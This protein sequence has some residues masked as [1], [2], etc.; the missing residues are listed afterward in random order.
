MF[1]VLSRALGFFWRRKED[2]DPEGV[3]AQECATL[4][5]VHGVVTRFCSD[6][7]M[8]NDQIYFAS[9]DVVGKGPLHIGQKVIAV[10]EENPASGVLKA[11]RVE[12]VSYKWEDDDSSPRDTPMLDQASQVLIGNITSCR[13]D[14]GCI[15]QTTVFSM[16]D[17]CDSYEPYKGDWVQARYYINPVTW[18]SEA[19]DVKP[20]RYKSIDQVSITILYG[21]SGVIDDSIFFTLDSLRLPVG[22]YPCRGD[23][24]SAVVI[25]SS[26]SCYI[27]RALCMTPLDRNRFSS[28]DGETS[29]ERGLALLLQNKGGLEVSSMTNFGMVK[30]GEIKTLSIC[31]ENRGKS[32]HL[33]ICCKLAGWEKESPFKFE[34]FHQD[35]RRPPSAS[36]PAALTVN[37]SSSRPGT[38]GFPG[39]YTGHQVF[40]GILMAYSRCFPS[41]VLCADYSSLSAPA[42]AGQNAA[43]VIG[44]GPCDPAQL[45]ASMS[46]VALSSKPCLS[47]TGRGILVDRHSEGSKNCIGGESGNMHEESG[48]RADT[49]IV[50]IQSAAAEADETIPILPGREVTI[51]ITC[52]AKNPG[53]FNDLLLLCFSNFIIGRNLKVMVRS[54]EE[55]LIAATEPYRKRQSMLPDLCSPQDKIVVM[56]SQNRNFRRQLPCFVPAYSVPE[57]LRKCVQQKMDVLTFEP[58]LAELLNISNYQKK[59]ATLLWLEDIFAE[60]EAKEFS[61]SGV[62]L[63]KNGG[64]LLLEVPGLAECRPSVCQGDKVLLRRQSHLDLVIEYVTYVNEIHDEELTLRVNPELVQS[65]HSEPMDVEFTVCRTTS[66]RCQFAVEQGI[67]LG[68]RVLFPESLILQFPQFTVPWDDTEDSV[69][70]QHQGVEKLA[71]ESTRV[72]NVQSSFIATQGKNAVTEVN[73]LTVATQVSRLGSQWRSSKMKGRKFFNPLLNEHQKLAVKRILGGECR[74]TPYILFGPPGTGKTVTL[75]EAVLQIHY[76]LSDSRI[77][78]CAPSNSATDLVCLRLHE[79]QMLEPGAMVRVNASSRIEE[80]IHDAVKPYCK[81]GEDIWKASRFRIVIC[82]CSSAGMFYQIGLRI[83]HFTHIFVDEAGQASEPECLIPLGLMSEENGQVVLAG[84]PWQLGPVIKCRLAKAYGLNVSLLERLM[85]RPMYQR[86]QKTYGACGS[87]NPLLV[88]KL[89]KNYR[90]HPALLELPSKLFY[91][92]EL[93]ACAKGAVVNAFL[94]W[95]KLP[96]KGFPLIFHGVRGSEMREGSN[97]S[98]FNPTEAVHIIRYCCILAKNVTTLVS[99]KDI[100]VITPYRKQ[101]EKIRILLRI[102]ALSDIKVGSVE[103]FQGQEYLVILISTVRSCEERLGE[104]EKYLLGFLSNPRRFNVAVTRP[105]ALLIVVG[106]PHVLIKDPCFS[107]FLEYSL[108]NDS[109][110]GCD[111]PLGLESLQHCD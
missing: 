85:T 65:Y 2:D 79:S 22:Y 46:Q 105:K 75:I 95:E 98:W 110:V 69:N 55:M 101:V 108:F 68:P 37:L 56:A 88:T 43:A 62:T 34:M 73:T 89:V 100:G 81:D 72:Q 49:H 41:T 50:A 87:Y 78:I 66:R 26:Q 38:L 33:L 5:N 14:G 111:L 102:M 92:R 82:T 71:E 91:H 93:E 36:E 59:F 107:A 60:Q 42:L 51:V 48:M 64:F 24:V 97:P 7:G 18:C 96:R 19:Y 83:G 23:V 67:H 63:R 30:Q 4:K 54:E 25:E 35:Q 8:V 15:N 13:D 28:S 32:P 3:P 6:Y 74:P 106:N 27:W 57:R 99:A 40:R 86:D 52:E 29:I 39:Q 77:M 11:V 76:S 9:D 45:E 21:R 90:S 103:E 1:V 16:N 70:N 47:L 104:D 17:V 94:S 53:H 84:D 80:T 31:I 44:P 20:L 10:V 109:Y 12:R 61:L 58:A